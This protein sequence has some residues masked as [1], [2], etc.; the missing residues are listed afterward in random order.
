MVFNS[1]SL[2]KA[3]FSRSLSRSLSLSLS[4]SLGVSSGLP[5]GNVEEYDG[6][7]NGSA[8]TLGEIS[9]GSCSKYTYQRNERQRVRAKENNGAYAYIDERTE[10]NEVVAFRHKKFEKSMVTLWC[11]PLG[12]DLVLY[13]GEGTVRFGHGIIAVIRSCVVPL[14]MEESSCCTSQG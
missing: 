7:N 3:R 2:S 14:D 8:R 10:L 6:D 1:E 4:L 5:N 9:K 12:D 13:R 11:A